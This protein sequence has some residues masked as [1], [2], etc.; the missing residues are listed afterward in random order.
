MA[1]TKA[2]IPGGWMVTAGAGA[3]VAEGLL[4]AVLAPTVDAVLGNEV[5]APAV[6]VAAAPILADG[7][8]MLVAVTGF[9]VEDP[10]G[11]PLNA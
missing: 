4:A 3:V 7:P 5:V 10:A 2:S 8:K 1:L 11:L 6:A 9:E